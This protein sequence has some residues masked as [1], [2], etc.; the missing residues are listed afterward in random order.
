MLLNIGSKFLNIDNNKNFNKIV[1]ISF[2]IYSIIY[3]Y[4]GNYIILI[5]ILDSIYF[6][7][8]FHN[9]N[10]KN[11]NLDC[12]NEIDRSL[13]LKKEKKDINSKKIMLD[14]EFQKDNFVPY[15]YDI[16]DTILH[17]SNNID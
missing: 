5:F 9:Y 3:K 12:S 4:S 1:L 2:T 15:T 8:R 10:E 7:K 13:L 11:M 6:M 16:K 17:I 14:P